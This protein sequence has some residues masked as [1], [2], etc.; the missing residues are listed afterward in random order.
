MDIDLEYTVDEALANISI[1]Y[2]HYS[3]LVMC[4]IGF[5]MDAWEMTLLTFLAPCAGDEWDLTYQQQ[6]AII[7]YYLIG[8][9]LGTSFWGIF[10][11]RFG[12]KPSYI[13]SCFMLSAAGLLSVFVHSYQL[14]LL[15]RFLTGFGIGGSCIAFDLLSELVPT[16]RRGSFLMY[17][18]FFLCMGSALLTAIAW[19]TLQ[20][21]NWRSLTFIASVPVTITALLGIFFLP[22]S[23]RWLLQKGR[24]HEA[25]NVIREAAAACN[26]M[27]P[28]FKLSCNQAA[29]SENTSTFIDLFKTMYMRKICFYIGIVNLMCGFTHLG[30]VM[31][32]N[33]FYASEFIHGDT[34]S[35][36]SGSNDDV[37]SAAYYYFGDDSE[38]RCHFDYF[39]KFI[40]VIAE[41]IG[42]TF[43]LA[44]LPSM[45]R[46]NSQSLFFSAAAVAVLLLGWNFRYETLLLMLALIARLTII[47]ATV[48]IS[49]FALLLFPLHRFILC[50]FAVLP[51]VPTAEYNDG[52]DS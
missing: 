7:A 4:G 46:V 24:K 25:E 30:T 49:I 27:L 31:L 48:N 13:S 43:A 33:R 10:A 32:I 52:A 1:G 40:G 45:G 23:P 17:I 16:H 2:F 34:S 14:L 19:G 21:T 18:Q 26:Q 42:Y 12:R 28:P 11:D 47:A 8:N 6:S 50:H 37:E 41:T 29:V 39:Y 9:I 51:P 3:L 35:A 15:T 38:V 5:M 36:V 20:Q 44:I 22:E